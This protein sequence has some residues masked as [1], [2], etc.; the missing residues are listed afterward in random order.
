MSTRLL[1]ELCRSA[2]RSPACYF[3]DLTGSRLMPG[4]IAAVQMNILRDSLLD[5][6]ES[7]G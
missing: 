1:G 7:S 2:L 3:E 5:R 6:E 4:V